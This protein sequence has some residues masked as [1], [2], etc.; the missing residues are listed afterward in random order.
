MARKQYFL[1]CPPSGNMI[2][3]MFPKHRFTR[4]NF[5]LYKKQSNFLPEEEVWWVT[6]L[7]IQ[8]KFKKQVKWT[9][10]A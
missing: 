7:I 6:A 2:I 5:E 1:V 4:L 3:G 10:P 9:N 8:I